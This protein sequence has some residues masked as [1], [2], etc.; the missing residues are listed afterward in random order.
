MR[1]VRALTAD[2][3]HWLG[4]HIPL[5]RAELRR[6]HDE[7]AHDEYRFL[8]GTYY[9]WLVRAAAE[10]PEVFGHAA[11]PLVGDLHVENY[12]T[13]RDQDQVRRWGVNDLDELARGSW[14]LDLVRLATSAV[15]APHL[16]LGQHEV[17]DTVLASWYAAT[18]G[19]A[20]DLRDAP[21]LAPL[22]GLDRGGGRAD[23][24]RSAAGTIARRAPR[25]VESGRSRPEV[26]SASA[27]ARATLQAA[28]APPPPH[29]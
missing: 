2:Y 6:K 21:R 4:G 18:P 3:E 26:S 17:C 16:S 20:V 22:V 9:L 24:W 7:L 29:R 1:D 12:G 19:A 8:R 28:P 15:L 11:V 5:D 14:L 23:G 10:V 25:S 27:A 13:W